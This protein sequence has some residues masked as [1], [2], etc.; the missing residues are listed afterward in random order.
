MYTNSLRPSICPL[1]KVSK[2]DRNSPPIWFMLYGVLLSHVRTKRTR[3]LTFVVVY[4]LTVF[5]LYDIF[6]S[7]FLLSHK[8]DDF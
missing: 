4:I 5:G 7:V 3:L 2:L 8:G 1:N 6:D